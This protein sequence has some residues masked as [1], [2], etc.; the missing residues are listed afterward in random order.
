MTFTPWDSSQPAV[1][2]RFGQPN[3]RVVQR[4]EATWNESTRT[5]SLDLVRVTAADASYTCELVLAPDERSLR[6]PCQDS[7]GEQY[8]FMLVEKK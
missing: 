1:E 5:Y 7:G 6:G 4:G 8:D 2:V 3:P